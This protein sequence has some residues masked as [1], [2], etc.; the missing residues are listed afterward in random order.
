MLKGL[1]LAH[2]PTRLVLVDGKETHRESTKNWGQNRVETIYFRVS[3]QSMLN[4]FTFVTI[5]QNKSFKFC[6]VHF[7]KGSV[8]VHRF[9]CCARGHKDILVSVSRHSQ[10]W[11]SVLLQK[12]SFARGD[13]FSWLRI[14]WLD[15]WFPNPLS[16]GDW[17]T[18]LGWTVGHTYN[19]NSTPEKNI[20]GGRRG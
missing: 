14:G 2:F 10:C 19:M 7:T 18:W 6:N 9:Q 1:D 3:F 11:L 13:Q 5:S 8:P 4:F 20:R 12:L 16:S 15:N 17:D